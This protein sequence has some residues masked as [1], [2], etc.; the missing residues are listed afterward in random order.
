MKE[1]KTIRADDIKLNTKKY[2]IEISKAL[3][4]R[5]LN[6]AIYCFVNDIAI[7]NS[8]DIKDLKVNVLDPYSFT[9]WES[10][11]DLEKM[12]LSDLKT[13]NCIKVTVNYITWTYQAQ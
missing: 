6:Y 8:I 3:P 2:S 7:K 10:A 12:Q 11:N 5:L 9:C 13:K 1:E 4:F